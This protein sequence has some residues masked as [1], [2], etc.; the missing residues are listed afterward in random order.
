MARA[1]D[2]ET[3]V[4]PNQARHQYWKIGV[5]G[6]ACAGEAAGLER[7]LRTV[8]GVEAVTVNPL[9]EQVYVTYDPE[10]FDPAAFVVAIEAAGYCAR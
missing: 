6:L 4:L 7:R 3:M 8:S 9:T 5:S 2:D 10:G 1:I